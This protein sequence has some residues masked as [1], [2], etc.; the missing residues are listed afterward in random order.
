[1]KKRDKKQ[2]EISLELKS[3]KGLSKI[4]GVLILVFLGFLA[5][6]IVWGV[7]GGQMQEQADAIKLK[8]D[9]FNER[10]QIRSI[11]FDG[12]NELN[13]SLILENLAGQVVVANGNMT[14]EITINPADIFSVVDLS[15]SMN[16]N[17]SG[18]QNISACEGSGGTWKGPINALKDA[19]YEL[20]NI[21]FSEE[22]ENRLGFVAYSTEIM[23]NYSLNLG[24]NHSTINSLISSWSV[25]MSTCICCGIKNATE[26]LLSQSSPE[27]SKTIIVM[28]DGNAN[29]GCTGN[30]ADPEDALE[31]IDAACNANTSLA[32]LTIHSVGLGANV[33]EATLQSIADCGDGNYYDATNLEELIGIY[34]TIA[35]DIQSN[36][37]TVHVFENLR[38]IF[39]NQTS[40]YEIDLT[41]IPEVLET[42]SYYFDLEGHLTSPIIRIEIYPLFISSTGIETLG[43]MLDFWEEQ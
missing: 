12:A 9:F 28:S 37:V 3:K 32:N 19:S 17:S 38:I 8:S 40:S 29:R 5:V 33:D 42:S 10:I 1:M 23:Q 41:E 34:E 7:L 25:D 14:E 6:G 20:S 21:L 30:L 16:C 27:I 4:I 35:Q 18:W 36:S 13:I 2:A 24:N 22:N 43:P 31:A 39:F 11:I 26:R 15:G